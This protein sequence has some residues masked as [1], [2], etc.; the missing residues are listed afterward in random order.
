MVDVAISSLVS[1]LPLFFVFLHH[2][3]PF[4]CT[5]LHLTSPFHYRSSC[6]LLL[7]SS[8]NDDHHLPSSWPTRLRIIDGG[9]NFFRW[10]RT[11]GRNGKEKN[12][13][14][15]VSQVRNNGPIII[16]RDE[17]R[18]RRE[19]KREEA[20]RQRQKE[21]DYSLLFWRQDYK[22]KDKGRIPKT[23]TN[24]ENSEREWKTH[25]HSSHSKTA[26]KAAE[27]EWLGQKDA[28]EVEWYSPLV[29][30]GNQIYWE[31]Q[32]ESSRS[33]TVHP[34]WEGERE[35]KEQQGTAGSL[36]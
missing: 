24:E 5:C 2:H 12:K 23:H 6:H 21:E 10:K 19:R 13:K 11:R 35:E 29:D 7:S 3:V 20:K 1:L 8:C 30:D 27:H 14:A 22:T 31:T 25:L 9:S 26:I 18:W 33:H 15:Q 28:K 32:V 16:R 34:S 4:L 36:S 17:K